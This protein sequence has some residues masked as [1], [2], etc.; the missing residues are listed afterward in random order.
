MGQ[1]MVRFD[2]VPNRSDS[3]KGQKQVRIKTSNSEKCGFTVALHEAS[4]GEKLAAMIIFKEKSGL[5]P[6]WVQ[7]SLNIPLM[8]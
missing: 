4:N 2:L 1:T 8:L 7:S 5:I 3:I 6:S